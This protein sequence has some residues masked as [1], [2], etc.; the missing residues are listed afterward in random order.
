MINILIT[1]LLGGLWHGAGWT[2]IA[3]GALHGLLLLFNH[4]WRGLCGRLG[5]RGGKRSNSSIGL[6][7]TVTFVVVVIAWVFFRAESFDGAWV[8][9]SAMF[10]GNGISLPGILQ[11]TLGQLAI[12]LPLLDLRFDG[13]FHGDFL[14]GY[15]AWEHGVPLIILL[16]IHSQFMPNTQELVFGEASEKYAERLQ[17]PKEMRIRVTDRRFVLLSVLAGFLMAISL[18][19]M[20]EVSEFLYF[21]F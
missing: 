10:G 18:A 5:I 13:M 20:L 16:L 14:N 6:S 7:R 17:E 11:E 12:W 21:Q 4:S 19:G 2:F 8:M 1:M 9:L 15:L 3:W